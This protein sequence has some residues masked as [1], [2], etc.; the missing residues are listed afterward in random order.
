LQTLPLLG[1]CTDFADDAAGNRL[2]VSA[3]EMS[4]YM[5]HQL[6]RDADWA[7]MAHSVEIRT[8]LADIHL[9]RE[10][11]PCIAAHPDITKLEVAQA[12]APSLRGAWL[13][14]PKTGFSIPVR[15]WL[16]ARSKGSRGLRGWAA[17]VYESYAPPAVSQAAPSRAA[18]GMK[19]LLLATDAYGGH[20]GI[21]FHG[22]C[23]A[24]ALAKMP[25]VSE[26][27]VVPRVMRFSSPQI[28]PKVRFL[29]QARGSKLRY[30]LALVPLAFEHFDLVICGHL[31]LLA[32][33]VAFAKLKNVPLVAQ[34]Y[35]I[36]A[37]RRPHRFTPFWLKHVD[38]VWSISSVTAE[39]MAAWAALA[40]GT[41]RI[42][43]CTFRAESFGVAPRDEALVRRFGLEGRKVLMTLARLAGFER[44][45][46]ID[47]IL[48]A[49]PALI[50]E[51]PGIVYMVVGDGDDQSRLESKAR[52]LGVA[53]HV[54]F[55][56]FVEEPRKADYL[57][58][59][60]VFALPG[61]GEG[62]GIVLLEALA[63]GVPV[64]AS[65]DDGSR[66]A[67]LGGLLG[68]LADP[69]SP[70]SILGCLQRALRKP[71]VVPSE[72]AT[73]SWDAFRQRVANNVR[74]VRTERSQR[75][76]KPIPSGASAGRSVH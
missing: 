52:S 14:R 69:R 35:G 34:V 21:A 43:P 5:R 62:F 9:L 7:G 3:L 47:E 16:G 20:G 65:I 46:G 54:I 1:A 17:C 38:A 29:A 36:E 55:A 32:V 57:R 49:L 48:E 2:A 68:E 59:A 31:N 10:I 42:I 66:E 53:S 18:Y 33:A 4:W 27:V 58:L 15:Q 37:W 11:A 28:P 64:V 22:R 51:E 41:S 56:G 70:E 44:Y 75:D 19:V 6:L 71:H 67:L 13:K 60:D 24:E 50:R 45:K 26:V 40:P 72:L 12:V 25:E 63:C 30:L 8:P 74:L 61:R 23:L 39:R 73:F 76:E